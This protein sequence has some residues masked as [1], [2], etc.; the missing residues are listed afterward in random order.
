LKTQP[1]NSTSV[2]DQYFGERKAHEEGS[3]RFLR[4]RLNDD[5]GDLRTDTG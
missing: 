3:S 1:S 5:D 4:R 2:I